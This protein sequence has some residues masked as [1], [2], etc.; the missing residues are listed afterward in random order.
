MHIAMP[1]GLNGVPLGSWTDALTQAGGAA[2]DMAQ[3]A[4]AVSQNV[5]IPGAS[6]AQNYIQRACDAI[7]PPR[8][9]APQNPPAA[10]SSTYPSAVAGNYP[11][12]TIARFNQSRQVWSIYT[13][14][15]GFSGAFGDAGEDVT[16]PPPPGTQ[17]VG[18]SQTQPVGTQNGGVEKD[19]K[20]YHNKWVWIG[21]GAV[22]VVGVGG[23]FLLRR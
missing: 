19:K 17:K 10:P 14:L 1:V 12:G 18:E 8:A 20:W 4:C 21:S 2:L 23:F 15:Q 22:V 13:P 5:P 7:V 6:G 11:V 3:K 9:V 16:P